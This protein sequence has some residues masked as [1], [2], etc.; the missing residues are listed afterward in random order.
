MARDDDE[1]PDSSEGGER[2]LLSPELEAALR[3]AIEDATDRRHEYA[4]LEHLLLALLDDER[5]AETIR[6]CGG[7][8]SEARALP[9]DRDQ[10]HRVQ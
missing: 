3:G 2:S 4:G 10:P 7:G 5:T 9:A 6:H 8:S 1:S